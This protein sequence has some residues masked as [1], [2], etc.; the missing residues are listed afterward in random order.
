MSY[1]SEWNKRVEDDKNQER[2]NAFVT[3]YYELEQNAYKAIL[4]SYPE[5]NLKGTALE[6]Q[7]SLGFEGDMVIFLGFMEGLNPALEEALDLDGITEETP[8]DL[9]INYEQLL[10]NMHDAKAA[11]LFELTAWDNVLSKEQRNEI[12]KQYRTDHIA[13]STKVGRNDPCPCGSGKKY[14]QCCGRN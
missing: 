7:E 4:E 2:F 13:V 11:W 12:A 10:Y 5:E 14:K 6:L 9:K 3:R 8:L 1:F